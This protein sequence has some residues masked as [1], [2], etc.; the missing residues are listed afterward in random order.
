MLDDPATFAPFVL[1]EYP[2]APDT[3]CLMLT[4]EYMEEVEETF[5]EAGAEGN[6][7]GWEAL[8]ESVVQTREPDL[9]SDLSFTSESGTFAVNSANLDALRRLA[10]ILR[11]AYHDE[12]LLTAM[13][14][15]AG[16][17]VSA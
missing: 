3:Y 11:P 4:D 7:H 2:H 10:S 13:I 15:D 5:E 6:G 8:A 14:R 16:P 9:V 1:L 12:A 17:D